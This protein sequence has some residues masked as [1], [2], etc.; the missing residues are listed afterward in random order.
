[1]AGTE[2]AQPMAAAAARV[3]A[4]PKRKKRKQVR[5][6]ARREALFLG[7][8]EQTANVA[9]SARASGMSESSIRRRRAKDDAFRERWLAALR[10]GFS[11]LET[12]LLERALNGIEKPVWHGGKQVGTAREYSDRLA[13]ALLSHHRGTVTGLGVKAPLVPAMSDEAI[14]AELLTRLEE[15]RVRL[16]GAA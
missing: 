5:W 1:M 13:L 14:Q 8:L 11:R 10:E 2:A 12:M 3:R 7:E 16:G 9:A 15:M 4:A 6:S